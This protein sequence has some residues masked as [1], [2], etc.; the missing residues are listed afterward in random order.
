[1]KKL[2]PKHRRFVVEYLKDQNGKQAA[3]RCG[4]SPKTAEQSAS[5][6]LRNVK[7]REAVDAALEKAQG[8][9]IVNVAYV[10]S[11][12][13]EV[14]ERCMQRAPVM[15]FDYSEKAMVQKQDNDGKDVWE[16]DSMGANKALELLGKHLKMFTDKVDVTSKG[17]SVADLLEA[18]LKK[19]PGDK[20]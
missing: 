18:A 1:M 15:V 8:K 13:K 17:E 5:R 20:G 11:G 10:L 16:F 6:L 7:V 19:L 9:A 3:I 2:S 12:L 4:L 14:A